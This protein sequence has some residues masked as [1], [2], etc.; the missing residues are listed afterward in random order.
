MRPVARATAQSTRTPSVV[1]AVGWS[2]VTTTVPV[3]V[4][5]SYEPT[6]AGAV[7]SWGQSWA[8]SWARS[9]GCGRG[10]GRGQAVAGAVWQRWTGSGI[11]PA[12]GSCGRLGDG[13]DQEV[14]P[15]M[16]TCAR[17]FVTTRISA[18]K[19]ISGIVRGNILSDSFRPRRSRFRSPDLIL[20]GSW[21]GKRSMSPPT[22][23]VPRTFPASPL[24]PES[25]EVRS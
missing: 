25:L 17:Q 23:P 9:G 20:S 2:T 16:L 11:V 3:D 10:R 6:V 12:R 5:A 15:P 24:E 21:R 7:W 19:N 1:V 4:R 14:F 13:Q 22:T 18:E 8:R